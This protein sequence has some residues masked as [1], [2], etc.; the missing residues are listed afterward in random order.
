M[1]PNSP[2]Q[3]CS[4]DELKWGR[5]KEFLGGKEIIVCGRCREEIIPNSPPAQTP[6]S[7]L[8]DYWRCFHCDF[9]TRDAAEAEAHF[10]ERDDA[11]EF[12]PICKWW[13]SLD[14]GEKIDT[15]QTCLQDLNYERMENYKQ[16]VQ[17]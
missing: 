7:P 11:E 12:K 15:L 3:I 2:P 10:G 13:A 5:N 9:A 8:Q 14:A 16:D 4:H 1:T 17:C 6:K